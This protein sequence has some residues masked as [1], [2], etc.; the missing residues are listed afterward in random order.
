MT[1][2]YSIDLL[3]LGKKFGFA[4]LALC[5]VYLLAAFV[6]SQRR[7]GLALRAP[8]KFEKELD[9]LSGGED[10]GFEEEE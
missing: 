9:L 1:D 4:Y 2:F 8:V 10:D 6:I 7:Y 5:G 3:G